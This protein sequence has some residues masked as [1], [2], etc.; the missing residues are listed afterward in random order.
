MK[1]MQD[2]CIY[3]K[4][5]E[6]EWTYIYC[7]SVKNYLLNLLKNF[8]IVDFITRHITQLSSL[9]SEP[10]CQLFQPIKIDLSF[11]EASVGF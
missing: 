5:R 3:K 7:T 2:V 6:W 10:T 1:S 8:Q 9:L 11:A 4:L